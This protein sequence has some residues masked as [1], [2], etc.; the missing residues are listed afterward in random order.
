MNMDENDFILTEAEVAAAQRDLDLTPTDLG[1]SPRA[2]PPSVATAVTVPSNEQNRFRWMMKALA[3][4]AK[5]VLFH[6][7]VG[8]ESLTRSVAAWGRHESSDVATMAQTGTLLRFGTRTGTDLAL[9]ASDVLAIDADVREYVLGLTMPDSALL[10]WLAIV[11]HLQA[12]RLSAMLGH[13]AP[14][15]FFDR[16]AVDAR[17]AGSVDEDFRWPLMFFTKVLPTDDAA[18]FA[19]ADC[20]AD[21]AELEALELVEAAGGGVW[22]VTPQGVWLANEILNAVSKVGCGV[23]VP[24]PNGTIGYRT[25]MF[26]RSPLHVLLFMVDG[27]ESVLAAVSADRVV[28]FLDEVFASPDPDAAPVT[29]SARFCPA[30]GAELQRGDR[31]CPKCGAPAPGGGL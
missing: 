16:A 11:E 7:T 20:D 30:C 22:E 10:T 15:H 25:M 17:L 27:S 21:I 26:V 13:R 29:A 23:A 18:A 19:G 12:L 3:D 28:Q 4:P 2:E 24:L 9:V 31:F 1:L 6:Y 8:D 5:R 14:E